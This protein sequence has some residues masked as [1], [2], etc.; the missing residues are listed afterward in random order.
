MQTEKDG[1]LEKEE[2]NK[3][4]KS[5]KPKDNG[6]EKKKQ[7]SF[8]NRFPRVRWKVDVILGHCGGAQGCIAVE[9]RIPD[10]RRYRD[11]MIQS[12]YGGRG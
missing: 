8:V 12:E 7:K 1:E 5:T 10:R 9:R 3:G 2:R 6:K 11:G 4:K